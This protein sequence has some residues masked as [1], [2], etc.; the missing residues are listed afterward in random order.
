MS[1]QNKKTGIHLDLTKALTL[2]GGMH[3]ALT[4]SG[5]DET[6]KIN[7][8][9]S[10][11]SET[12]GGDTIDLLHTQASRKTEQVKSEIAKLLQARTLAHQRLEKIKD[13]KT[14][15]QEARMVLEARIARLKAAGLDRPKAE[16]G[17]KTAGLSLPETPGRVGTG[18]R[19]EVKEA[20]RAFQ[21]Q[22]NQV[23]TARKKPRLDASAR[24]AWYKKLRLE[25][26]KQLDRL[27]LLDLYQV[28]THSN[29]ES[30]NH[31][32]AG[33]QEELERHSRSVKSLDQARI[34]WTE[35]KSLLTAWPRA[36][37]GLQEK[38][39][40]ISD[41]DWTRAQEKARRLEK[42]LADNRRRQ[43][44]SGGDLIE[45]EAEI[46]R[47]VEDFKAHHD[48][49]QALGSALDQEMSA[50]KPER[51]GALPSGP[52]HFGPG[53]EALEGESR[54]LLVRREDL[55]RRLTELIDRLEELER[56]RQAALS[57]RQELA[58]RCAAAI[59]RQ[60][61]Q[62]SALKRQAGRIQEQ[63][64][65]LYSALPRWLG[66]S[67]CLESGLPAGVAALSRV[68]EEIEKARLKLSAAHELSVW[69][70]DLRPKHEAS[71]VSA[72]SLLQRLKD[73]ASAE[74]LLARLPRQLKA[75]QSG[76]A[77]AERISGLKE[78]LNK[79]RKE[80]DRLAE[81]KATLEE[82]HKQSQEAGTR[83][84]Q[85]KHQLVQ[86]D[87]ERREQVAR[88]AQERRKL[89]QAWQ[90]SRNELSRVIQ[91]KNRLI[92][93]YRA[94]RRQLDRLAAEKQ[95]LEATNQ[96]RLEEL[97]RLTEE[98]R[99]LV[100]AFRKRT[101]E[102]RNKAEENVKLKARLA[103]LYP[104]LSFFME[105]LEV[106][107]DPL[108]KPAVPAQELP[109]GSEFFLVLLH[110]LQQE[111][112]TL[113][114]QLKVLGQERLELA[115]ENDHLARS[116][117]AIKARLGEIL[118][119]FPFFW[120]SWFE[121]TASLASAQAQRRLAADRLSRIKQVNQD[122]T[123]RLRTLRTRLE[124]T[125]KELALTKRQRDWKALKFAKA[126][127]IEAEL[128]EVLQKAD[129]ELAA[130]KETQAG[131]YRTLHSQQRGMTALEGKIAGI[132]DEN[133][134]LTL[135]NRTLTVE[136]LSLAGQTAAGAEEILKLKAE[137]GDKSGQVEATWAA[138]AHLAARSRETYDLLDGQLVVQRETIQD[139]RRRLSERSETVAELEKAQDR[140]A[141]L[142]WVAARH[143]GGNPQVM[144]ALVKLTQD[145]GFR[146]AASIAGNRFQELAR[147]A[148]T[149]I[150]DER[151]AKMA[152]RAVRRGL[153]SVLLAGGIVFALPQEPSKATALTPVLTG[154]KEIIGLLQEPPAVDQGLPQG[155]VY[156]PSLGFPF[157]ISF[158]SPLE[159]SKGYEH[160]QEVIEA[161]LNRLAVENG[162]EI[163]DY[164]GLVRSL[165]EPGR[166]IVLSRLREPAENLRLLMRHFP[167]LS[168]EHSLSPLD[169]EKIKTLFRLAS[170][171][172][173]EECRFWDRLYSEFRALKS[174]PPKSLTMLL[175]HIEAALKGRERNVKLEY[176]G[177]LIPV[178]DMEKL[179]LAG[180]TRLV[181][182]YLKANIRAFTSNPKYAYAGKA[183]QIDA[184]S[185]ELAQDMYVAA[186]AFGVPVTLLLLIAHQ[187][188]YFANVLGDNSMSASP[189]QIYKPTQPLILRNMTL[190]GL[191]VP[192]APARLQDHLTLATYMAAFHLSDLIEKHQNTW[193]KDK[194]PLCDLD[195]VAQSYNGSEAYPNAV[196]QKKLRLM[197]FLERVR[198]TAKRKK[199]SP[200]G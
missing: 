68:R 127:R 29:L 113:K 40:L 137:L 132:T 170:F 23:G 136:K 120:R 7:V 37:A 12:P 164:L 4:A 194:P 64:G 73:T 179:S 46:N 175:S 109:P 13:K 87:Q 90:R 39:R 199:E 146:E 2:A 126:R 59:R 65:P 1:G 157:D 88:L 190:K 196:Y 5:L 118:P 108:K 156:Y 122:Q 10:L 155:P 94:H 133:Q 42:R 168:Q 67:L 101:Q 82:L 50:L 24:A 193:T 117:R 19:T 16:A 81:E 105:R 91:D 169:R 110:V 106:W 52:G 33:R 97:N 178:L 160:I 141:I 58:E 154:S 74:N 89:I 30:L 34:A 197:N 17:A 152:R 185:R 98:K 123:E 102:A 3:Q 70:D 54:D 173:P 32:L 174:D 188:S 191:E 150:R 177:R 183:N 165:Y 79:R 163:Q 142:F 8:S 189:F 200:L 22:P 71:C 153:Y 107:F 180:F 125:E 162:L 167:H 60:E 20:P 21:N 80:L 143:G 62:R 92:Q 111:N 41:F 15:I 47:L 161:E 63:L 85:E 138:L 198:Q 114:S 43:E 112:E 38:A 86:I 182:P 9:P 139:L 172:T 147:Q 83:L 53:L 149:R 77:L 75:Y 176:A 55:E 99:R 61:A 121:I 78:A 96:S 187:E 104:L 93:A 35:L 100:Q 130:L 158:L 119:F 49:V 25:L 27:R 57:R 6:I 48:R 131:L 56:N 66:R 115:R 140:L 51:G 44:Q 84:A 151:W 181:C 26:E 76:L 171:T 14:E 166:T 184:Y 159:R 134:R 72:R 135:E 28:K 31:R 124:K 145:Q 128:R 69:P 144:E 103:E 195:R 148:L 186:R 11:A 45:V 18:G 116:H 36:A 129:L 95:G 192:E